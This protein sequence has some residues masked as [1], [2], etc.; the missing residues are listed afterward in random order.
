M[1]W[2]IGNLTC[3][4]RQPSDPFSNL[5]QQGIQRCQLNALKAM[6]PFL[7]N[8]TSS[9]PH[10]ST[11][12]QNGYVLLPKCDAYAVPVAENEAQVVA[13]YLPQSTNWKVR[14]WGQLHL[15]NG[16][17]A[18]STFVESGRPTAEFLSN[19]SPRL[20]EVRYFAHLIIDPNNHDDP[21]NN[22]AQAQFQDVAL[23]TLYSLP[24]DD[25]LVQSHGAL[26][27]CTKLGEDS[28]CIIEIST[29]QSVVAIIPHS[30]PGIDE[31]R[32]FLLEKTGM[33]IVHFGEENDEDD[34]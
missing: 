15:P 9:N 2:I 34:E 6:I 14:R 19:N 24:D 1:E 26:V 16:Q 7:D 33:Q 31:D 12:L 5:A 17:I 11:D 28:L 27:S 29:I 10:G 13:R 32:Y 22:Q 20:A 4:I 21:G 3:E 30:P 18:R 25:L 8:S 23:V